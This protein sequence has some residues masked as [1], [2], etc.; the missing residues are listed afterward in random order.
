MFKDKKIV[1]I[2]GGTGTYSILTGLK[3]YTN[4]ITAIVTMADSGGSAKI[5]RDEWGLLPSSDIRKSLIALADVSTENSLLLRQLFRYRYAQGKGISGM[6]FGILFLITLT[7]ILNSQTEAIKKA[8]EILNIRGKVLPV[9]IDKVH[10]V[11]EYEDGTKV[12][13]EHFIDEP[14]HN[15][16]IKIKRLRTIPQAKITPETKT[17]ISESDAIII[18][19]GGFYTTILANLV[20]S[21]VGQAIKESG[22]KKIFI[23]NLMTE[24]GQTYGFTASKF[25]EE[26]DKYLPLKL[27]DYVFINNTAIP[28][29]ILNRYTKYHAEPIKNDLTGKYPFKVIAA[30]LLSKKA[31]AKEKG[32]T[33][34]RSLIRH[35]SEKLARLCKK[36]LI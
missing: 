34:P 10:L 6:T 27:L 5:E 29:K 16:M 12:T 11:A 2:G 20:V 28:E 31:V 21:G 7:K 4:N 32:D 36:I 22:A 35:S 18:G 26:M 9:S 30:D 1:V 8:G 33:L 15:G 23:L 14:K 24:Y 17:A 13:G 3:K 19:P 25:L